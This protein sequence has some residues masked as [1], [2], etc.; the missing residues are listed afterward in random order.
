MR[1]SLTRRAGRNSL[2]AGDLVRMAL[3]RTHFE[4]IALFSPEHSA[5][6]LTGDAAQA[7]LQQ[8]PCGD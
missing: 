4:P 7:V 1:F 3:E 5:D 2:S 6:V 8:A